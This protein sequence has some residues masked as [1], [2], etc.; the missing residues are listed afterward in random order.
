LSNL[1]N[2]FNEA[3]V[4]ASGCLFHENLPDEAIDASIRALRHRGE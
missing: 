2:S 3:E 1:I 4:R